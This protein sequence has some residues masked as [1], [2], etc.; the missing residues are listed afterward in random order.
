MGVFNNILKDGQS[1]KDQKPDESKGLEDTQK[2]AKLEKTDPPKSESTFFSGVSNTTSSDGSIEIKLVKTINEIENLKSMFEESEKRVL[3]EIKGFHDDLKIINELVGGIPKHTI[4]EILNM[5]KNHPLAYESL[6]KTISQ[7]IEASVL[8]GVD[9][10]IIKIVKEAGK[11]NSHSLLEKAQNLHVCSKNTL[12]NHLHRLEIR[13]IVVK[14]R[15]GHEV[16]YSVAEDAKIPEIQTE[17]KNK[18]VDGSNNLN[19]VQENKVAV[20]VGSNIKTVQEATKIEQT[21]Q[22][23]SNSDKTYVQKKK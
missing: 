13:E 4:D 2:I 18:D 3:T 16:V 5:K 9:A 17:A 20:I 21:T 11:I 14:H 22:L 15:L 19:N 6:K 12:Y 1:K 8:D 7:S 23:Q 10:N